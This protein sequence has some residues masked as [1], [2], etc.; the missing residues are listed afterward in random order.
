LPGTFPLLI[1]PN[2]NTNLRMILSV[3]QTRPPCRL[4]YNACH[5]SAHNACHASASNAGHASASSSF[6]HLLM[7]FLSIHY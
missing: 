7:R 3:F 6:L 1:P 2:F 4:F 5:V